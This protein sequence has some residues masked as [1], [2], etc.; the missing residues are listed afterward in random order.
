LME[1]QRDRRQQ[2]DDTNSCLMGVFDKHACPKRNPRARDA[3]SK[4]E[5]I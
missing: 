5:F 4:D 1:H 2:I 3:A